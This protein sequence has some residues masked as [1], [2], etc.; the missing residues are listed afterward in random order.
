[1]DVLFRRGVAIERPDSSG[2]PRWQCGQRRRAVGRRLLP[3]VPA[4]RVAKSGT[5]VSRHPIGQLMVDG[6]REVIT[7]PSA[8]PAPSRAAERHRARRATLSGLIG[9]VST[10]VLSDAAAEEVYQAVVVGAA[11]L[12]GCDHASLILRDASTG[13]LATVAETGPTSEIHLQLVAPL[14]E[15]VVRAYI[16]QKEPFTLPAPAHHPVI[17]RAGARPGPGV[18]APLPLPEGASGLLS[19]FRNP[20]GEPL[21]DEDAGLLGD[22]ARQVVTVIELGRARGEEQRLRMVEDRQRIARDLHDN[23]IQD[24]IGLGML[25]AARKEDCLVDTL[26]EAIRKLRMVVFD[27][28]QTGPARLVTKALA[29]TVAEASRILGHYPSLCVEGPV[30][31]LPPVV[32]SHLFPVLRE[33]LSNV[34]RHAAATTTWVTVEVR[35]PSLRLRVEDDGSGPTPW[36]ALG[37][38]LANLWERAA[39]LG[40]DSSLTCRRGGGSRLEWTI[41]LPV[42]PPVPL[43]PL[44]AG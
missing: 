20:A 5:R 11:S 41:P 21:T 8:T 25:L 37:N 35:G 4:E 27:S 24:L 13:Q 32:S 6:D 1:V 29:S 43:V 31:D 30:D 28:R 3:R 44:P 9:R 18:L 15:Q 23:V 16:E 10:M 22:L 26:E 39:A 38:G 33:A 7:V 12:L 14:D 36:S 34:A 19:V 2:L 17:A 42:G 40:G